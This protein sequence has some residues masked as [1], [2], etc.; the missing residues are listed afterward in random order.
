MA[1]QHK[2]NILN[3]AVTLTPFIC[4]EK[5]PATASAFFMAEGMGFEPMW[6]FPQTVFKTA[7][8]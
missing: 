6:G 1:P 4:K 7:S 3:K 8:L 5:A 2:T